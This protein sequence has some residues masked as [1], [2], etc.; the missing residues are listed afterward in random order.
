[1]FIRLSH[2]LTEDFPPPSPN[3]NRLI[4]KQL[5]RI[6]EESMSNSFSYGLTSHLGTHIDSPYHFNINGKRIIDF[7]VEDY[8]FDKPL[9]VDVKKND[10]EFIS[11]S[12]LVPY[13]ERITKCDLLML[14]T[15]F[16][17]YRF[18]EP[19]RYARRNPGISEDA[20]KYLMENFDNIRAI[21]IDTI[22]MEFEG[23]YDHGFQAHKIL[24]GDNDHPILLIEDVN[25]D[26]DFSHLLRVIALPLFIDK[27]DGSPC[28]VV[29]ELKEDS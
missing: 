23:N 2:S 21:A 20:A 10:E 26:F 27:V 18:K 3:P 5:D 28:T 16:S 8:I 15:G 11:R 6:G 4:I 19:M 14:R 12:D 9:V 22:S 24:L 13:A 29:A 1:M 17:K 7:S 25:L